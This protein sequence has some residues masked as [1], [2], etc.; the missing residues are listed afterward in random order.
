[1]LTFVIYD[2]KFGNTEKVAE[3]I[4]RGAGTLGR[5]RVMDT[6]EAAGPFEE[7]PDLLFVGGPT[8]RRGASPALRDFVDALPANLRDVP[9]ALFDT[10]YR[11]STLI[12]GSSASAAAKALHKAGGRSVAP[13]E[14]FF[15]VRGGSLESQALEAGELERAE[16][17]GRMV[18]AA[19]FKGGSVATGLVK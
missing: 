14:S 18:G 15:M 4:A 10:R 1:M 12:T 19:A 17:W 6:M 9:V 7:R 16:G 3:S 5:V 8:Q 11:G 2:T 13:P